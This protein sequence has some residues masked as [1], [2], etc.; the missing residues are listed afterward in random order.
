MANQREG[1][2]SVHGEIQYAGMGAEEMSKYYK[3]EVVYNHEGTS[4]SY[5]IVCRFR[6]HLTC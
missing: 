3:G 4:L 5:I 2:A 6:V 1:F